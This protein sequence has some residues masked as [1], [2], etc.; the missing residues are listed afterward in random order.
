M[1]KTLLSQNNISSVWVHPIQYPFVPTLTSRT[2]NDVHSNG[3]LAV[4]GDVPAGRSL[5]SKGIGIGHGSSWDAPVRYSLRSEEKGRQ[6]D[7]IES[8]EDRGSF[9]KGPSCRWRHR[10]SR[11]E[12]T[13]ER[14]SGRIRHDQILRVHFRI[15]QSP[16]GPTRQR[17]G[18]HPLSRPGAVQSGAPQGMHRTRGSGALHVP[19]RIRPPRRGALHRGTVVQQPSRTQLFGAAQ[20]GGRRGVDQRDV[21]STSSGEQHVGRDG[22]RGREVRSEGSGEVSLRERE[23]GDGGAACE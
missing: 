11:R 7:G 16:L 12:R 19:N 18:T 4:E 1:S 21:E 23:E 13:V 2:T 5:H 3:S 15:P 10:S 14:R 6:W 9:A 20:A 17:R 8:I 22:G